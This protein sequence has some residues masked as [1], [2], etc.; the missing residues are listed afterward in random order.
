MGVAVADYDRDGYPDLFITNDVLPNFL[1]HN[2]RNGTFAEVAFDAGAAL[3]DDGNAVSGMGAD[4]RDYNNDGLPDIVF[5]AL[6]GQTFPLF[7][8]VGKGQFQDA[9]H[10]C[11]LGP[12]MSKLSGWGLALADLNNDGWKDLFTANSHV[13]DNIELRWRRLY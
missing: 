12:L 11:R 7:R 3:P 1:F 4:F 10:A 8:N 2:Q 9:G 13:T 5:T 6:R